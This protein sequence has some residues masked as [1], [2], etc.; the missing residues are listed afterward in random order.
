MNDK[1]RAEIA[2]IDSEVWEKA[3]LRRI[4]SAQD[5]RAADERLKEWTDKLIDDKTYRKGVS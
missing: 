1:Q 5:K 2:K 4:Q 3:K